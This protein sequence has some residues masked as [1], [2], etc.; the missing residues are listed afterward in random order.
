MRNLSCRRFPGL[1]A[2]VLVAC[3]PVAKGEMRFAEPFFIP[4]L[5]SYAQVSNDCVVL[6]AGQTVRI[7]CRNESD[8]A[9]RW[10]EA[11]LRE[12]F[13]AARRGPWG[14]CSNVP[15]VVA[16]PF[17]GETPAGGDEAYELTASSA[18]GVRIRAQAPAG[19]R[20]A[21]YTLRQ[22]AQAN[23]GTERI[24]HYM[25]PGCRVV[26]SPALAFRGLHLC[27]FPETPP[28]RIERLIRL[29]AYLKFNYVVI[30]PWGVYRW[31]FHPEFC[32]PTASVTASELTRL[33]RLGRELGVTLCPQLNVF[34]HAAM[35]R[36][37]NGKHTILDLDPSLQP[38]FEPTGGWNW[39]LSNPATRRVLTDLMNELMDVFENPPYFHIGCDEAEKP[40]CATCC[41]V[42]YAGLAIDHILTMRDVA[43]RRKARIMMWHD[44][45]LD[46]GRGEWEPFYERGTAETAKLLDVLPKDV[47]ICDWCYLAPQ[48]AYPTFPYFTSRGY[49]V[50]TCPWRDVDGVSRQGR[51]ARERGLMGLLET[52]WH[53]FEGYA[54]PAMATTA[55]NAAWGRGGEGPYD[56]EFRLGLPTYL[57]QI[58]WDMGL[59]S[60]DDTG[61][62]KYDLMPFQPPE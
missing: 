60:R 34:G 59:D 11:R 20:H 54:L 30:E 10:A 23:R 56:R 24:S 5:Q 16:E 6:D 35:S 29:A 39:C 4:K 52:T 3:A 13:K 31:K 47:V 50:L 37:V 45:L 21:L 27:W 43:A 44:M 51:E 55:A 32:W 53:T 1:A 28:K 18:M 40:N 33:V 8:Q 15:R 17:A 19:V 62:G 48:A 25:M 58:G 61:Y 38:I 36:F 42:P 41:A 26:D 22:M 9:V 14:L 12:W 2:L 7:A 57:R 46:R 49:D